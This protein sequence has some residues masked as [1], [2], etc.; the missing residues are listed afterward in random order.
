[1]EATKYTRSKGGNYQA[2]TSGRFVI[3]GNRSRYRDQAGNAYAIKTGAHLAPVEYQGK[4]NGRER[5]RARPEKEASI[6]AVDV[7]QLTKP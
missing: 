5:Y 6:W 3:T 1:M 7:S 4:T 2:D